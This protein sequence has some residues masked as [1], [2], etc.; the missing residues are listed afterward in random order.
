MGGRQ[1]EASL[2][3]V[4]DRGHELVAR[5]ILE[6]KARRAGLDGPGGQVGVP[7]HPSA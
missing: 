4:I 1:I 7:M 6:K 3:H 2:D 5:G